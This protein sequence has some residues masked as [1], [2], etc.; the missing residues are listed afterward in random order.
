MLQARRDSKSSQ[1]LRSILPRSGVMYSY[2]YGK[3]IAVIKK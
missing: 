3:L 2:F 1:D